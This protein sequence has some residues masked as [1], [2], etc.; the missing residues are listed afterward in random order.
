MTESIQESLRA[1]LESTREAF[2]VFAESIDEGD[3]QK[4]S[5]NPA[6]NVGALVY[7][8]TVALQFLPEDVQVIRRFRRMPRPPAFLFHR[9]NEWYTRFMARRYSPQTVGEAYDKAHDRVMTVLASIRDD[10]WE[11][12]L[13][14]PGWD[15]MLSGFVSLETLFHYPK[16]HF[17]AHREDVRQSLA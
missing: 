8:M 15:P 9:F 7:H 6:W 4:P 5:V 11:R 3:W 12:G 13:E 1:E 14:Y 16:R 17:E 10:E 2:H